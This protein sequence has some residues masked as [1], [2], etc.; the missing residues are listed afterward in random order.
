MFL[1][2]LD[3]ED[4]DYDQTISCVVSAASEMRARYV[5]ENWLDEDIPMRSRI[6]PEG[7]WHR[8]STTCKLIGRSYMGEGVVHENVRHG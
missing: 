2:I 3:R 1:Y 6:A 7:A 8:G 5:A 4:W